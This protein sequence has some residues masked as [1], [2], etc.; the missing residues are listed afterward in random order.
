MS[1]TFRILPDHGLVYV[2]YDGI[3]VLEETFRAFDAYARHPQQRPGQK[4]LVDLAGITGVEQDY[5]RLMALQSRKAD[6][7]SAHEGQ[8]MIV[9]YAPTPLSYD[10]SKMVLRSWDGLDSI[11]ALVQ[12]TEAGALALL[13][14]RERSFAALLQTA[15]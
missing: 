8:T 7:F 13:G 6:L 4:Q 10:L 1:V 15:V 2:R 12:Q 5:V 9:Y 14:L 3:A 11:V